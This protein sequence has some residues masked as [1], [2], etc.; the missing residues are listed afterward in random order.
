GSSP[1][2][3][4]TIMSQMRTES[5]GNAAAVNKTDINWQLGHPSVGLM[6]VIKGTFDAF[7]GPFRNLGPFLY[8]V[9]TNAL[10]NIDARVNYAL[11][12]YGA[13]WQNVLGHGH[14]YGRGGT[15]REH[16]LGVGASGQ[17]Y[18]F[19]EDGDETVI[20]G[21][22]RRGSRGGRGGSSEI[23]ALLAVQNELLAQ[24]AG[25]TGAVPGAIAAAAGSAR[26][27]GYQAY[28]GVS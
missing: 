5:G 13:N 7:A 17:V 27:A 2:A 14:G 25:N 10:A 22:P 3:F 11:H 6:Q 24:I 18:E 12:T 16:I 21:T 23:A 9:S 4:S 26:A 28:Y 1:G 20:P 8:G 19:G 15:I